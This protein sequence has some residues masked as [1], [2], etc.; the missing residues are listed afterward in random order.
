[1]AT[2]RLAET[3]EET[4]NWTPTSPERRIYSFLAIHKEQTHFTK[5]LVPKRFES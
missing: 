3:Q 4:R 1:M 5:I 2:K